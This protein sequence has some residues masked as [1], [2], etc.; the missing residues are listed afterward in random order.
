LTTTDIV[1]RLVIDNVRYDGSPS[2][3]E[4]DHFPLI[5]NHVIDSLEI[6]KLTALIEE[7]FGVQVDDDDVVP[8]NFSSIDAIAR[9]VESKRR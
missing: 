4:D 2:D 3:L 8:D 9:F 7:Q 1:R 5:D 6:M